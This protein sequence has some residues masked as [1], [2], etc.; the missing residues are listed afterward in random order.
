[1]PKE[2]LFP[3]KHGG[4]CDGCGKRLW[5]GDKVGYVPGFDDPLCE[6]CVEETVLGP[7]MEG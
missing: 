6:E 2:R 5:E 1:M 3:C 4:W 7:A